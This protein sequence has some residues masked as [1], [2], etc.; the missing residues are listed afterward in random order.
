MQ[1]ELDDM[2]DGYLTLIDSVLAN[3]SFASP[4][5]EKTVEVTGA[6][7]LLHNP[8]KSIPVGV[9]RKLKLEIGAAESAQLIAGASSAEMMMN[10]GRNFA[11]FVEY[12]RLF[13]AY[14]PR[15][16]TQLSTVVRLLTTDP[17]TRQAGVVIFRPDDNAI[18]TR[19]V[20]CT[21]ELWF[22]IR[23]GA[24]HMQT[25]M[26][27][28]D[29]VWGVTYDFWQF[30]ALQCAIS[31]AIGVPVG[32]YRHNVNSLHIYI[33]RDQA[34][35]DRLHAYD[36]SAHPPMPALPSK[37]FDLREPLVAIR[38][39]AHITNTMEAAIGVREW[40]QSHDS[41]LG[42]TGRWYR[43]LLSSTLPA[44]GC[45]LCPSCRYV[46]PKSYFFDRV[47]NYFRCRWCERDARFQLPIGS[48][49]RMLLAQGG[50]CAICEK[51]NEASLVVDHDHRTGVARGLLCN[52]CNLMIGHARDEAQLLKRGIE[53][54]EL[55]D[56]ANAW[57]TD[58]SFL[59][60]ARPRDGRKSA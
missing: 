28:N 18:N 46:L 58:F 34:I 49:G 25:S 59:Y 54:L 14:G 35:L 39:W 29:C 22:M 43:D 7:I 45:T 56:E 48:F 23:D 55:E 21:L 11:F 40:V 36:G 17:E 30:T 8:E 16:Y 33:D 32:T 10:A 4:R 42:D 50:V 31:R 47:N 6:T 52:N 9:G 53:Y 1:L 38:R 3:G 37:K 27:S 2:Q 13:G 5:G 15:V 60:R 24:L 51:G 57:T 12:D 44:D 20:P 19:D 41:C 26:R